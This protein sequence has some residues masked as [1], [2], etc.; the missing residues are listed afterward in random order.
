[1]DRCPAWPPD[2]GFMPEISN[3]LMRGMRKLEG[4][5]NECLAEGRRIRLLGMNPAFLNPLSVCCH[6]V[7]L[8]FTL[9]G[10]FQ[11]F[12]SHCSTLS[13]KTYHVW[14]KSLSCLNFIDFFVRLS[15]ILVKAFA[16]QQKKTFSSVVLDLSG[17]L[18]QD[19]LCISGRQISAL[20]SWF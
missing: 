14:Y 15:G 10:L 11:R 6:F 20:A 7:M 5:G 19:Q 13:T 3:T 2:S 12:G 4:A 1:M 8:P 18:D 9:L 16:H 17:S